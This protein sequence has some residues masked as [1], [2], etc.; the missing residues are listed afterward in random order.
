MTEEEKLPEKY[1][2]STYDYDLEEKEH[3][4]HNLE[5]A[6]IIASQL[7]E[8]HKDIEEEVKLGGEKLE[9]ANTLAESAAKESSEAVKEVK[10]GAKS[11]WNFL[12]LKLGAFLGAVGATCGVALGHLPGLAI[13]AASGVAT[14]SFLGLTVSGSIKEDVDEIQAEQPEH[15]ERQ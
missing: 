14:G 2:L 9:I 11:K 4:S 15:L 8:L 5:T 12:P 13:G 7:G 1:I 6:Y 10:K 3:Q